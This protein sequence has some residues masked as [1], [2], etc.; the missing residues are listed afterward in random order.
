MYTEQTRYGQD[1]SVVIRTKTW[2]DPV[3]W[4]KKAAAE[5]RKDLVFTCS[6]S[7]WFHVDAD[8]W[9]DEAWAVV[10]SCPN[11]IFQILT[12]RPLRIAAHLPKDWGTGYENVWLGSSLDPQ[13]NGGMALFDIPAKVRFLSLEPLL[14]PVNLNQWLLPTVEDVQAVYAD[15]DPTWPRLHWVIAGGESG[16][17]SRPCNIEWIRSIVAQ[18]KA[19]DVPCFVKQLGGNA[20]KRDAHGEKW[21]LLL[22][23]DLNHPKGG[24]PEEWPADLRVRQFPK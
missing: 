18:C 12:K 16:P 20:W 23:M 22:R 1:P 10:K 4:Q 13:D 24:D 5:H 8:R 15:K 9:R 6:W 19:A 2:N 3:R 21:P 17:K 14:G 7:D 11:L